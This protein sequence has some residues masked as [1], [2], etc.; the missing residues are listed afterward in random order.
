[1][2]SEETGSHMVCMFEMRLEWIL[3]LHRPSDRCCTLACTH[4]T[5]TECSKAWPCPT[6]NVSEGAFP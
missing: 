4:Q 3:N 2:S 5:C 6:K 1:M